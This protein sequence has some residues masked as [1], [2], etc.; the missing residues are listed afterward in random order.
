MEK[1]CFSAAAINDRSKSEVMIDHKVR[2]KENFTFHIY[3]YTHAAIPTNEFV[4][5]L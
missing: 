5:L 3:L 2:A 1:V 4:L